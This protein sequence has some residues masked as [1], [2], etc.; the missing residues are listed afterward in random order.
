MKCSQCR[1]LV[2]FMFSPPKSRLFLFVLLLQCFYGLAVAAPAPK[3]PAAPE[4]T[5]TTII[6]FDYDPVLMP[7]IVAQASINGQSPLPFV[8]DTGAEG[9]ALFIEPWAAQKL[10]LP[11]LTTLKDLNLPGQGQKTF[12]GTL[13]KSFKVLGSQK[14]NDFNFNT[15][16]VTEEKLKKFKQRSPF[17]VVDVVGFTGEYYHG[18]QQAGIIPSLLL[19]LPSEIC[20]IDFQHKLITITLKTK[21]WKPPVGS[22]A[23]PL[24]QDASTG[25]LY[26]FAVTW[27]AGKTIDFS[28]DTGS[29][30]NFVSKL[31]ALPLPN[32]QSVQSV[33]TKADRKGTYDEVLLPQLRIGDLA[34]PNVALSEIDPVL[35][36]GAPNILGLDFFSRF[37]IT[38]DL[39]DHK[40]YLKRRAD[41]ARLIVPEGQSEV[42]LEKNGTQYTAAWVDPSSPAAQAGLHTG[43]Q[44]EKID[45]QS[46]Q[47]LP[48]YV[49]Q[50]LL[51]GLELS[52]VTLGVQTVAGKETISFLRSRKFIG[53]RHALLG[54]SLDWFQGNLLVSGVTPGSPLDGTLKYGDDF[55]SI[56][57]QLVSKM[58]MNEAFQQL[59]RPDVTLQVWRDTDKTWQEVHIAPLPNQTQVIVGPPPVGFRYFFYDRAGWTAVPK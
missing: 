47:E 25:D 12:T 8:V 44:V 3:P 49:A 35:A 43:D 42:R 46:L 55:Y 15:T 23:I 4:E 24:H 17:Q 10:D 57:G 16:F 18:P 27:T 19:G 48:Q 40:M 26:N 59:E 54:V 13:L 29:P 58:T 9:G 41:Y 53:R 21:N 45:G 5:H 14:G 11:R 6:P 37:F 51:D 22:I 20:Q 52:P 33:W 34:E 36:T 1:F 39:F 7:Y 31:A 50:A 32:A 56:N 28:L 30:N 2:R 38:L